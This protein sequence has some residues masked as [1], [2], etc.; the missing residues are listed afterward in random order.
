V[1]KLTGDKQEAAQTRTDNVFCPTGPGGGVEP[2]SSPS[3]QRCGGGGGQAIA[4][5]L[6]ASP[7]PGAFLA[8]EVTADHNGDGVTDMARVG[9]PALD[10]PPPPLVPQLP[11]L[12]AHERQVE[13]AFRQA[14]HDDPD[15][16]ADKFRNVLKASTKPGEPL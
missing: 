7:P 3:G 12:T 13:E 9:V 6:I 2:T 1:Q 15:G 11:N 14:F 8:P 5:E 16:M 4:K 10:T